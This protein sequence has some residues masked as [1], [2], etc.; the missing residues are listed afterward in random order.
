MFSTLP[1]E[2]IQEVLSQVGDVRSL[3]R[4]SQTCRAV[5]DAFIGGR[6]IIINNAVFNTIHPSVLPDAIVR[7]ESRPWKVY[8]LFNDSNE[9]KKEHTRSIAAFTKEFLLTRPAPPKSWNPVDAIALLR[10]H[11]IVEHFATWI[12]HTCLSRVS[13]RLGSDPPTSSEIRRVQRALYRWDTWCNLF[14]LKNITR[15]GERYGAC[16]TFFPYFSACDITQMTCIDELLAEVIAKPYNKLVEHDVHWADIQVSYMNG[17]CSLQAGYLLARGLSFIWKLSTEKSHTQ[18]RKMLSLSEEF[19]CNDEPGRFHRSFDDEFNLGE[20]NDPE[21]NHREP[22]YDDMDPG[23]RAALE[24]GCYDRENRLWG[25]VFWDMERLEHSEV[26]KR[27]QDTVEIHRDSDRLGVLGRRERIIAFLRSREERKRIKRM[28]GFGWWDVHDRYWSQII[29]NHKYLWMGCPDTE[30]S[31]WN[32]AEVGGVKIDMKK[33]LR[34]LAKLEKMEE[35][36]EYRGYIPFEYRGLIDL[37]TITKITWTE[38]GEED[39]EAHLEGDS[40]GDSG[41]DSEED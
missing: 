23:P 10:L 32:R 15:D 8:A 14:G 9:S 12:L 20:L 31:I 17:N 28:G 41:E 22:A 30:V 16:A 40:E 33:D 35:F 11:N 27:Q 38:C 25:Y 4:A 21:I 19:D 37:G 18:L 1:T 24:W 5:R 34:E 36:S 7:H 3:L 6:N 2:L 29:W 13:N 26:L 39:S